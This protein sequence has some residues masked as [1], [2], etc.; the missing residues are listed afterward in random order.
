M[1]NDADQLVPVDA[2]PLDQHSPY[3]SKGRATPR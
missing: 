2:H 1:L 3:W